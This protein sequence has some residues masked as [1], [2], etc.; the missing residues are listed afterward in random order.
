VA[1]IESHSSL[2]HHPKT[3]R[4]AR[5]LGVNLPTAVGMLHFLWWWAVEYAKD[6]DLS[7]F[8][9]AEIAEELYWDGDPDEL[10]NALISAGFLDRTDDGSLVIHDWYD[11]AGKLIE[12]IE[13]KRQQNAERQRRFRSKQQSTKHN[14][15]SNAS[16]NDDV[17]RDSRVTVTHRNA[18]TLP[19]LTLP[20][21]TRDK[22]NDDIRGSEEL[23]DQER[24]TESS[25][26][27]SSSLSSSNILARVAKAYESEI[28]VLSSMVQEELSAMVDEY[29][30]D[31]IEDAIRQAAVQNVRKLS[32]VRSILSNWQ[33]EGRGALPRGQPRAAPSTRVR[34]RPDRSNEVLYSSEELG[35]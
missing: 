12:D 26:E 11:Y 14:A 30:A 19:N 34:G 2:G 3:K 21:Q 25:A 1:W 35:F 24:E 28:G 6:G 9:A 15:D 4:L 5:A 22:D 32:Y 23:R 18:P 33:T 17:T 31:W 27:G 7:D 29:P 10:L 13:K 20:N 8:D 16:R